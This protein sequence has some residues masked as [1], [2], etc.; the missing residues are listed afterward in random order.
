[1]GKDELKPLMKIWFVVCVIIYIKVIYTHFLTPAF[2]DG[3]LSGIIAIV[4]AVILFGW[5]VVI[6]S[7]W[8]AGILA[9]LCSPVVYIL[10][11]KKEGVW[12]WISSI[13][14]V[15]IFIFLLATMSKCG[16]IEYHDYDDYPIEE[17]FGRM[18]H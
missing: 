13:V 8:I 9:F 3:L 10:C 17:R 12:L 11:R 18:G 1:M 16:C 6:G 2:D 4:F 14:S 15:V 5:M 7:V